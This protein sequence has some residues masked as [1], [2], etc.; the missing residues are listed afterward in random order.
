MPLQP[1][2][3]L[4]L[5]N[6]SYVDKLYNYYCFNECFFEWVL[7]SETNPR[8][9]Y[10]RRLVFVRLFVSVDQNDFV[11][12]RSFNVRILSPAAYRELELFVTIQE[13]QFNFKVQLNHKIHKYNTIE[14]YWDPG[15]VQYRPEYFD[16]LETL[17]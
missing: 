1:S 17:D 4:F 2:L 8:T 16:L 13:D 10:R 3:K 12:L 5:D 7:N 15:V 6:P 14:Y 11:F 9:M